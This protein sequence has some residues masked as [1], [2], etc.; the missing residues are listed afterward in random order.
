VSAWIIIIIIIT[1]IWLTPDGCSTVQIYTQTVHRL[2]PDGSSTVNINSQT[3]Q[4]YSTHLHTNSTAVQYIFT[5]KQYSTHLHTNSTQYRERN[6]H[7]NKKKKN[8]ELSAVPHLREFW[9]GNLEEKD[10]WGDPSVDWRI[11]LRWIFRKWNVGLWTVL[12]WFRTETVG[13]HL[14]MRQWT[15][16]FHKMRGISWLATNRLASQ[17]AFCSMQSVGNNKVYCTVHCTFTV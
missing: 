16:G 9:W 1:E 14:W 13:G 17:E 11:I 2:T 15:F 5:H 7:Y 4:Q 10:H 8:W 3:V 6:R 12:G